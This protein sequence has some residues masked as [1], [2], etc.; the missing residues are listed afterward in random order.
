MKRSPPSSGASPVEWV[1]GAGRL[2]R[3]LTI[4]VAALAVFAA[5]VS[6]L[7]LGASWLVAAA[8]VVA[9]AASL[10]R[11]HRHRLRLPGEGPAMLDGVSGMLLG[12][13]VTP[14]FVA[15]EVVPPAG[16]RRRALLFRDELDSEGFRALLATLRHG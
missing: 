15:V 13:A 10:R 11:S 6:G 2:R 16:R 7:P 9:T 1:S 4:A 5:F 8:V 14:L 12:R 3:V